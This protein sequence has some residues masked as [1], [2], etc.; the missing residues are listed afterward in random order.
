MNQFNKWKRFALAMMLTATAGLSMARCDLLGLGEE[1]EDN[2]ALGLLLLAF[3]V[4]PCAGGTV[5]L[6]GDLPAS[7]NLAGNQCAVLEGTV[8]VPSGVEFNAAAGARIFGRSGSALFILPGGKINAIGTAAAPVV[9]TSSQAVG[10]R[11]TGDWGGILIVG[12]ALT[13]RIA[14]GTE[15]TNPVNY[16]GPTSNNDAD[17]SGTLKYVRIEFA[18]FAVSAGNELNTLSMYAVGSGTTLEFVQ[19]H[20]G[21]DDA[22]EW[23]GGAVNGRYL[24]ATG[25]SDDDFD[26]DEGFIGRLQ[27]IIGYKYRGGQA[28]RGSNDVRCFEWDGAPSA[29]YDATA[30]TTATAR[31]SAPVVANFT[32][33][34]SFGEFRDAQNTAFN[35]PGFARWREGLGADGTT[36]ATHGIVFGFDAAGTGGERL[37]CNAG[38]GGQAGTSAT[39]FDTR[40]GNAMTEAV[41]TAGCVATAV[42]SDVASFPLQAAVDQTA[43]TA[44]FAPVAGFSGGLG[45]DVHTRT[46][47]TFFENNTVY[48]AISGADW[49]T[50]WIELLQN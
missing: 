22:F 8:R 32:C 27:Y 40:N 25:T 28:G 29:G 36:L 11:T 7:V 15:G 23:F 41:G 1:E 20:M 45:T 43:G 17:S 38:A 12:N 50:G 9:F 49:T 19:A 4:T 5:S 46:G 2:S 42:L 33:I 13:N 39:L 10:S 44:N 6:S 14:T 48:G 35:S 3:A 37:I 30:T 16:G 21:Q 34:G 31:R 47:A 24:I 18:G 26:M